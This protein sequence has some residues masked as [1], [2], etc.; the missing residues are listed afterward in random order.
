MLEKQP[1]KISKATIL[2]NINSIE[3]QSL[4]AI[5]LWHVFEHENQDEMLEIFNNKLK[6]KDF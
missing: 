2:D 3:D 4:D 5:T 6:E 1:N